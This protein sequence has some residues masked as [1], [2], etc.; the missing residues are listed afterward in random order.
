[1]QLPTELIPTKLYVIILRLSLSRNSAW[2]HIFP[3]FPPRILYFTR[4]KQ[5]SGHP[6]FFLNS[7]Y[8]LII[9]H[10]LFYKINPSYSLI[11]MPHV[12]ATQTVVDERNIAAYHN[13]I[14]Q[15]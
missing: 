8:F 3:F 7:V 1:M 6:V 10:D 14:K 11:W 13:N 4:H 9:W 2:H 5:Q 15:Q 12:Q